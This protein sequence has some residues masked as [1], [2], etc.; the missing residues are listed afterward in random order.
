MNSI[1]NNPLNRITVR[2]LLLA[3]CIIAL[4]MSPFS[5]NPA[6]AAAASFQPVLT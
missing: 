1:L 5:P 3:A 6:H 2:G 4:V